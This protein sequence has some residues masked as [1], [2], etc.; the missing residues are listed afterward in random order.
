MIT[1]YEKVKR[2]HRVAYQ[3][4]Q[5]AA[6]VLSGLT[7]VLILWSDLPKPI[8]ALPAALAAIAAGL[9]GI[10]QWKEGY[11]RFAYTGEALKSELLKF[12]TQTT[13]DYRA[14]L[15]EQRALEN[16]VARVEFLLLNEVSDWRAQMQESIQATKE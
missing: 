13:K 9:N 15:E 8:Q 2:Q 7:P 14:S 12:K 6:V 4:S 16:F 5:V 11:V 1:W 3:I 10:F